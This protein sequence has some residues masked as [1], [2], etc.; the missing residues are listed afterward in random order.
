MSNNVV[1]D[2]GPIISFARA[3]RHH[4]IYSVYG[5]IIL[6][7]AVYNEIVVQGRGKPGSEEIQ[8][9]IWITVQ[10]PQDQV[11]VNRLRMRFGAGESEAIVLAIELKAILL[12]D[13]S[14]VIKETRR[15][16]LRITST[17]LTLEEAKRSGL[18]ETV[19]KELDELREHGFRTT[20]V[21]VNNSLR[22]M[23]ELT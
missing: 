9:A 4:I 20:P 21:L 22:K 15:R 19:R 11:E 18:I 13:E 8:T 1:S 23:G 14:S 7:P 16:G 17:H 10:S 6:P 12:I 5:K 3:N 2:S